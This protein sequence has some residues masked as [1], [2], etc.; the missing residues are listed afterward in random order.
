MTGRAI[1]INPKCPVGHW[2]LAHYLAYI[3]D[4]RGAERHY[5]RAIEIDPKHADAHC[6]LGLLL[7]NKRQD[8]DGAEKHYRKAL[9]IDP[10]HD[11]AHNNLGVLLENH[12]QDFDGAEKHY[13]RAIDIDP[14]NSI[15]HYNLAITVPNERFGEIKRLLEV[16]PSETSDPGSPPQ[17]PADSSD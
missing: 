14:E 12:R 9:E 4:C 10:K 11:G 7:K 13:R 17:D 3:C 6:N 5:R 2:K 1:T 8:Y 16:T 15:A